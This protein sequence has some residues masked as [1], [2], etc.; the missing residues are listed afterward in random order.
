MIPSASLPPLYAGWVDQLL[1]GPIP[2]ETTATCDACAMLVPESASA[3]ASAD[4]GFNPDTKCCTFLPELWNFLAG[5]VLLD[6]GADAARGRATVE[7]RIDGGVAVT[8]LGLGRTRAFNLLY[9]TGG[10][11]VFGQSRALRC[12]HYLHDEGGLC[13]VWRHRESTCA[14]WFCKHVRGTVGRTFWVH[15]YQLLHAADHTLAG[16]ALLELGVDL[17][18]LARLYEPE[19]VMRPVHLTGRDVDGTADPA[20]LRTSWGRWRGRERELYVACAR[21][22]TPLTWADVLRLGGA[23]LAIYARLVQDAYARLMADGMPEHPVLEVVQITTRGRDRVRL[24]TYSGLDVLEMPAVVAKILPY[25]DGR[26]VADAL[27]EVR[28]AE[29]VSVDAS[30]VR[31][32]TDFGVLRDEA[33][34]APR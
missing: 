24:E 13:G 9:K 31:K 4:P 3:G 14:T 1:G 29:G 11:Q 32:L 10:S 21:L 26:P 19:R 6:D 30:L 34:G 28:R 8:P 25:F 23:Q 12:P 17:S 18:T 20:E 27:D 7:A 15:L 33:S 5:G 22:V 2:A 16:W